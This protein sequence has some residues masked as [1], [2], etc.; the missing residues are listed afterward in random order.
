MIIEKIFNFLRHYVL[1]IACPVTVGLLFSQINKKIKKK[2][3]D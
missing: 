3:V 2:E 1:K